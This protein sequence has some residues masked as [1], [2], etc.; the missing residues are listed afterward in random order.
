MAKRI[1]APGKVKKK[2]A[3]KV[4]YIFV[5]KIDYLLPLKMRISFSAPKFHVIAFHLMKVPIYLEL[6][7]F[8]CNAD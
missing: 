1:S 6:L 3:Q 8:S 7:N 2:T 4:K 5:M